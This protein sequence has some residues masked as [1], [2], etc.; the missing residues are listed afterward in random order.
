MAKVKK[1]LKFDYDQEGDVLD[2]SLDRSR[3]ALTREVA[4]DF[5]VRVDEKTAEILGFMILNIQKQSK[6][7]K[8]SLPI[9]GHFELKTPVTV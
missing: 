9:F 6:R 1:Q 7:T 2:I 5:F 8:R 4:E 3:S